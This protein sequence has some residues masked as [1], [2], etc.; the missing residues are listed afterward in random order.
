MDIVL[1]MI[2]LSISTYL[3]SAIYC[4]YR[5]KDV[6]PNL[7]VLCFLWQII[8]VGVSYAFY[9]EHLNILLGHPGWLGLLFIFA[10][11]V[12]LLAL[13]FYVKSGRMRLG[14][15]LKCALVM[16]L[17]FGVFFLVNQGVVPSWLVMLGNV[18]VYSVAFVLMLRYRDPRQSNLSF[19][20]ISVGI[21][22][23]ALTTMMREYYSPEYLA[24]ITNGGIFIIALGSMLY[25][26]E[27]GTYLLKDAN[28]SLVSERDVSEKLK[29]K[30]EMVLNTIQEGIWDYD[31]DTDRVF[32]SGMLRAF[33]GVTTANVENAYQLLLGSLYP[34]D[35]PLLES[36]F[37]DLSLDALRKGIREQEPSEKGR[38]YRLFSHIENRYIWVN[39]RTKRVKEEDTGKYH[40]YGTIRIIQGDRDAEERIYQLAYHD[41]LTGL[42]NKTAFFERLESLLVNST[43]NHALFLMDLDRFKY[44][45]DSRGHKFGN[46]VLVNVAE[47]L[48]TL[49]ADKAELFRYGGTEF[50]A[51]LPQREF[52]AF[53]IALR[54][55]FETPFDIDGSGIYLTA[56]VGF[57]VFNPQETSSDTIMIRLDLAKHKAKEQGGDCQVGYT[58][59]YGR[60]VREK[61]LLSDAMREAIE[62]GEMLMHYQPK[63]AMQGCRVV[64]YEALLRWRLNGQWIPPDRIIQIAEETGQIQALGHQII[65]R[66][67]TD[68]RMI[69]QD[70]TIAINLSV[71]QLESQGFLAGLDTLERQHGV[72]PGRFLFEITENVLMQGME[73][74]SETLYILRER[75]Y[76][77]SLDDFGTGYA[78]YNYLS[79]LPIDELK[80]DKSLSQSVLR[81][82]RDQAIVRHMIEIGKLL[83]FTVVCEGIE[84]QEEAEL[85]QVMG[86]DIG[87]GYHYSVPLPLE[88]VAEQPWRAISQ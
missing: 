48:A 36:L 33:F 26:M 60:E 52:A 29:S 32:L 56:S 47:R 75:G 88:K 23:L 16:V 37:G 51:L 85:L 73:N 13:W 79:R 87:Q 15:L 84:R 63:F 41:Q 70:E 82:D 7:I 64:G 53:S 21:V 6:L 44:I 30:Y 17:A 69:P 66:V 2:T 42:K 86:C 45:N 22:V 12:S 71:M 83:G 62:A 72:T 49:C 43:E 57:S 50:V 54:H 35:L 31:P 76:Q 65:D 28:R 25:Y 61:V 27:N 4:R 24:G 78:S 40:L 38:D 74:V 1:L 3:I 67:F 19:A 81:S 18:A 46:A 10:I 80:L 59:E 8:G 5:G 39:L 11:G 55:L 34:D 77:V 20:Q 58:E 68:S 9:Y 14:T